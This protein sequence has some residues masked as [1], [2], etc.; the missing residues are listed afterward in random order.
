MRLEIKTLSH[1][2]PT[3]FDV[4]HTIINELME[5]CTMQHNGISERNK[6]FWRREDVDMHDR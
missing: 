3:H 4:F 1:L 6:H 5:Y 2:N